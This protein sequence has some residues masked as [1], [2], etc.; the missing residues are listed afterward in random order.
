MSNFGISVSARRI[1]NNQVTV[2][3]RCHT[4]AT[5]GPTPKP[6]TNWPAK[7]CTRPPPPVL[8]IRNMLHPLDY[9]AVPSLLNRD[10]R[11]C[12]I[13]SRAMPVLFTRRKP[14]NITR[15]DLFNRSPLTLHPAAASRHDQHLSQRMR[16]HAVRAPGSKVTL[17]PETS[18]GSG[19]SKSG[20]MRTLPVNHSAGPF[21]D[22]C[23][24]ALLI[25]ICPPPQLLC[26]P[27]PLD[28]NKRQPRAKSLMAT[29]SKP[30]GALGSDRH[31]AIHR[32]SV[33]HHITGPGAAQPQHHGRNLLRPSR[34]PNG[35][36]LCDLVVGLL[37]PADHVTSN[38]RIDQ[39]GIDRIHPDALLDVFESSRP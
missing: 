12:R 18:A 24:P 31:S 2:A 15:P 21:L 4:A 38:L 27:E 26:T 36:T 23:E 20:S 5:L 16:V 10:M 17:A 6:P 29:L 37:V 19:A 28:F 33:T 14:H 3:I 34:T 39:P 1:C 35:N 30:A 22:A 25:S 9:L 7:S 13:R 32:Q 11:Q 8:L